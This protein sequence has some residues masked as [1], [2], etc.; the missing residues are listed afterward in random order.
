MQPAKLGGHRDAQ[1]P[2]GSV[3][4]IEVKY[5]FTLP[6][7]VRS[8]AGRWFKEIADPELVPRGFLDANV[9]GQRQTIPE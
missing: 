5:V 9:Q 6:D 8:T 2:A 4:H 1:R 7:S 3:E